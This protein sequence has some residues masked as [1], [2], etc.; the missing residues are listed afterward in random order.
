MQ[1]LSLIEKLDQP[2][3]LSSTLQKMLRI[4]PKP[5]NRK[6]WNRLV[7]DSLESVRNGDREDALKLILNRRQNKR[8]INGYGYLLTLK[9]M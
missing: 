4:S 9:Q 1:Y 6:E 2:A 3:P 7:C 5:A 8:P